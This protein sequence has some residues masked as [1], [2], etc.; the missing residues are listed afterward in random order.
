MA[1]K[2]DPL[3]HMGTISGGEAREL[4]KGFALPPGTRFA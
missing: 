2:T 4:L 3:V 1:T